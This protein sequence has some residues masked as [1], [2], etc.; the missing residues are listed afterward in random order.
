MS[1]GYLI[2]NFPPTLDAA[3]AFEQI[4]GEPTKIIVVEQS[5]ASSE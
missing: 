3:F 2:V 1:S 5:S 4:I